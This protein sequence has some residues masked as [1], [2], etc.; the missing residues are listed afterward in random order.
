VGEPTG[1]S[2]WS[3][4]PMAVRTIDSRL[5]ASTRFENESQSGKPVRERRQ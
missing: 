5:L 1:S 4:T 3:M 2:N